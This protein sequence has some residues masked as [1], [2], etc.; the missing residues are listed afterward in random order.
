MLDN[1]PNNQKK[2]KKSYI[3]LDSSSTYRITKKNKNYSKSY[4]YRILSNS[5]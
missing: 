3:G 5:T 4:H 2:K 1:F